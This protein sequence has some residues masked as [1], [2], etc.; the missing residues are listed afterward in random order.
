MGLRDWVSEKANYFRCALLTLSRASMG[1]RDWVSEKAPAGFADDVDGRSASMGLRDWVSEKAW[2]KATASAPDSRFNGAPRLG[3]GEGWRSGGRR[4]GWAGFNGAPRLG[5]G[6]GIYMQCRGASALRSASMGLRDWVSEKELI[7]MRP[8][9][10]V[11]ALQWGS[12]TGSRRRRVA[13]TDPRID[14]ARLQ[15]GSETGSRRREAVIDATAFPYG[16]NGAPRLGLGEGALIAEA[17]GHPSLLQWGSETGSRRWSATS[18]TRPSGA[19]GFNGAPRLGL[20]DG[21]STPCATSATPPAL[22]W[23]SETG[24]RRW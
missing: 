11:L 18:E 17:A 2:E 22:Q 5:L 3:L 19:S 12:E 7:T 16:F 14:A 10:D 8:A 6:E 23:G 21:G 24:S 13:L 15:W 20:G 4:W 9:A 1:L